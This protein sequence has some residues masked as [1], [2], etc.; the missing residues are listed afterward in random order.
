MRSIKR[1]VKIHKIN[2]YRVTCLFNNGESRIENEK[3]DI[4]L[5]TLKKIVE[6]LGK[7]LLVTI[8]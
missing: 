6:G 3:S 8:K 4:E 1:I 5:M 7:K 2:G